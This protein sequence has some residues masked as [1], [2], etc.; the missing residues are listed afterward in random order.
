MTTTDARPADG[1]TGAIARVY[2]LVHQGK[3]KDYAG[4]A[5][6]LADLVAARAPG[7]R[8]L[9]DVACGTG[10]HLSHLAARFERVEG[11]EL[12]PDMLA[13]ARHRNPGTT[14]HRGDMRDFA[15]GTTYSAVT[16]MF[17]SIG[18]M[19]DQAELDAALAA[20]AAHTESGGVVV[21]EP[22]WFPETFTPGYVGA[23]VV[24]AEGKTI[25]RVS[26]SRLEDGATR[27]DVHYLVA[28]PGEGVEHLAESHRITLFPRSAYELAFER[29]GLAA[30]FLPGGPSGRGLFVGLRP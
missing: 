29:A 2:D 22:W 17:S 10:L 16:C 19:T 14:V 5:A 20:F 18:H 7:A 3:G 28:E 8:S 12:S 30:E 27:I 4:E 13:A 23:A 9:L 6:D 26:H 24:E 25:S 21:V 1:Y 11:L 15:L